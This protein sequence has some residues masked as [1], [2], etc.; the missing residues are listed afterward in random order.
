M[1]KFFLI[2][3]FPCL[4]LAQVLPTVESVVDSVADSVTEVQNAQVT[5]SAAWTPPHKIDYFAENIGVLLGIGW[6]YTLD[7]DTL[8]FSKKIDPILEENEFSRGYLKTSNVLFYSALTL[9]GIGLAS[10]GVA[11][12]VVGAV[13]LFGSIGD[14]SPSWGNWLGAGFVASIPLNLFLFHESSLCYQMGLKS[15]DLGGDLDDVLDFQKKSKLTKS[16]IMNGIGIAMTVATLSLLTVGIA[17]YDRP[18]GKTMY[19]AAFITLP[20]DWY[21][22]FLSNTAF[23]SIWVNPSKK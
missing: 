3:L 22:L 20:I 12:L 11:P 19:K 1:K 2:L 9:G 17:R 23:H 6:R 15:Y 5:D 21:V 14:K 16:R 13:A 4:L 8:M 18:Y 10:L 7:G